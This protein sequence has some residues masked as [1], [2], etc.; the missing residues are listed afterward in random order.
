MLVLSTII[1]SALIEGYL[2]ATLRNSARKRPSDIFM[3]LALWTAVTCRSVLFLF[4]FLE[5][6]KK[7]KRRRLRRKEEERAGWS[8]EKKEKKQS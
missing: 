7:R 6:E 2:A 1:S 8:L 5:K 3:M 4:Y